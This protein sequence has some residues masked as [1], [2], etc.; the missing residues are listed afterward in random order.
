MATQ[1]FLVSDAA[2]PTHLGTNTA[3]LDGTT[4]GWFP[5]TLSSARGAGVGTLTTNTVAGATAGV[6]AGS[7]G[8]PLEWVS[9]P[10]AADVTI[11]GAITGNLWAHESNMSANVAIN[12][13]VHKVDGATG[14]LTEIVKSARTTELGT[15]TNDNNFTATPA[16]GVACKRGDRLRVTI[17]GDDAGTMGTGFTFTFSYNGTTGGADGDSYLSF[18]ETFSFE[19]APSGT[20]VYLTDTASDATPGAAVE[21]EAWTS[22][23]SGSTNAITNTAAGWTT[24]IQVTNT[25]G[26]TSIEW[27]TK[28][29]AAFTLGGICQFNI[30]ALES[31]AAANASIKAEVA[32]TDSDGTNPTVVGVSCIAVL[33]GDNAELSTSDAARTADVGVDDIA[34]TDQQRLRFRI[35]A[36]D[37]PVGP[38]VTGHTVTVTYNGTSAAAAGDTYVTLPQSIS[39][40]VATSPGP[41]FR[42]R[43]RHL[44]AIGQM[45]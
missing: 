34:V 6:E 12:F 3:R 26:G 5:A 30:R 42:R 22:R 18:T 45:M 35:Y 36:D 43:D 20:V 23:G 8:I 39:E 31:N 10:L 9:P 1:L 7:G 14:A 19:S 16:S 41:A 4:G 33:A 44:G 28:K 15:S 32:V 24:P 13:R 29:L 2:A 37:Y 25:A 38:L 11:S 17:F 27:Y 40:F 21:K